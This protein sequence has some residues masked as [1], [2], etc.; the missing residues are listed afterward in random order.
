MKAFSNYHPAVIMTYFISVIL[1]TM[2][3]TNPVLTLSAFCG[4]LLFCISLQKPNEIKSDVSFYIPMFILIS[5]TN[6]LF[7]HNGSTPLFFMN[8]NAVTLEAFVYGIAIGIMLV[9]VMLWCKAY[10]KIMTSDKFL[11]IFGKTIPKISLIL[12]MALRF[13][14]M[15]KKQMHKVN[16]AQKTMGLYSQKSYVDKIKSSIAVMS[17]LVT[18]SLEN[19]IETSASMKA[20]G[21]GTQ[22]RT[23]FNIFHF[24]LKDLELLIITIVFLLFTLIGISVKASAFEYYPSISSLVLN[25]Y[26][27]T[28]YIA[29]ILLSLLPFVIEIKENLKWKY[30]ISKI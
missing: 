24:T 28:E 25:T 7:S 21:Y 6:P 27:I 10:S 26:S 1:I 9:S 22:S 2:L 14:P 18:W 3:V 29:F 12:S 23:N 13:I 11:Y 20:R 4:G 15:F 16:N 8:G 19:S 5:I 17:S 30:Y